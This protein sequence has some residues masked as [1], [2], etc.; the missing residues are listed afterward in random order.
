MQQ[1][2]EDVQASAHCREQ[3]YELERGAP[4]RRVPRRRRDLSGNGACALPA[5]R[6]PAVGDGARYL[7]GAYRF[8]AYACEYVAV[9]TN[10]SPAGAYQGVGQPASIFAI[11][12][13]VDQMAA[14]LG[15]DPADLRRQNLVDERAPARDSI[16][17]NNFDN[18]S[19]R[20][21]LDVSLERIGY[22]RFRAE[23]AAHPDAGIGI[24]IAVYPETPASARPG[25]VRAG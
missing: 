8:G 19:F 25:G 24:G 6:G 22:E 10:K 20:Q 11:E 7:P 23:Q 4:Q 14:R 16:T 2:V 15:R 13:L 21:S 1:R 12:R 9:A 18:A 3:I 5:G 17:R